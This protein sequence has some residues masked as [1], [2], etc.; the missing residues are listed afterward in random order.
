MAQIEK[1]DLVRAVRN[2]A[3]D[4]TEKSNSLIGLGVIAAGAVALGVAYFIRDRRRAAETAG[5]AAENRELAR[6]LPGGNGLA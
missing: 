5:I 3:G 4:T 2:E 6:R 1:P